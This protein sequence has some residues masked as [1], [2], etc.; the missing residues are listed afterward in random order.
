MRATGD[1]ATRKGKGSALGSL[2]TIALL[3]GA[4]LL[5]VGGYYFFYAQR[6]LDYLTS[7]NFRL[8]AT[9]G[10]QVEESI[11]AQSTVL[12]NLASL[13]D[14]DL[15]EAYQRI[16][17]MLHDVGP[18]CPTAAGVAE[19]AGGTRQQLEAHRGGYR[20]RLSYRDDRAAAPVQLCGWATL[21]EL[22]EP[23]L[24]TRK[25]FDAVLL[26]DEHGEVIYQQGAPDLGV[27]RLDRLLDETQ[28]A[29]AQRE[30]ERGRVDFSSFMS[31]SRVVDVQASGRGFKVFL[32][33]VSLSLGS[34]TGA[35]SERE[36]HQVWLLGGLVSRNNFVLKSLAFS[37]SVL[38]LLL[39]VLV[40]VA[41]SW[42]LLK[43]KLLGERQRLRIADV[44]LLGVCSLLGVSVLLLLALDYFAYDALKETARGQ[45]ADF[46]HRMT[47]NIR[48]E[49]RLAA[50]QL[51]A[52]EGYADPWLLSAERQ[53]DLLSKAPDKLGRY[54]FLDVFT[55]VD[56]MGR[57]RHKS[58]VDTVTTPLIDVGERS[59]YT[60]ARA[61]WRS[62]KPAAGEGSADLPVIVESIVGWSNGARLAVVAKPVEEKALAGSYAVATLA[63]PMLSA[64]DPLLA[65]GF[66]FAVVDHQGRVAFHSDQ[67]RN[68]VEDLFVETDQ[69]RRLRA[70]VF[71][72]REEGFDVRYWGKDYLAHVTPVAELPWTVVALQDKTLLRSVNAEWNTTALLFLLLYACSLTTLLVAVA[73]LR[74]R[75]RAD[76]LWPDPA[77]REAYAQLMLGFVLLAAACAAAVYLLPGGGRLVAVSWLCPF[78][79]L[80]LA[81]FTL[82]RGPVDVKRLATAA[83]G[84]ILLA[85]LLYALRPDLTAA[86]GVFRAIGIV[87]TPLT[88]MAAVTWRA[89]RWQPGPLARLPLARAYSVLGLLLVVLAA[90]LPT[91]GFFKTAHEIHLRSFGRYGQLKLAVA[92]QDRLERA[93]E[94]YAEQRG[95]GKSALLDHPLTVS[96]VAQAPRRR[97]LRPWQRARGALDDYA[98]AF[99]GTRFESADGDARP[100]E[101]RR[102]EVL[103]ALLEDLLPRYSEYTAESRELLHDHA[104]DCRWDWHDRAGGGLEL[105][106]AGLPVRLVSE[107]RLAESPL[108][109]GLGLLFPRLLLGIGFGAAL[110]ALVRFT[111]RRLFLVDL[112]EP[113]WFG[114]ESDLPATV[115]C[116]LLLVSRKR[117]W[118]VKEKEKHFF[119]LSVVE[120]E[121]EVEGWPRRRL[122]LTGSLPD[123]NIL[124]E[125]FEHRIFDA[126]F[127]ERKLAFLEDL[128]EVHR[129]TVVVLSAVSPVCLVSADRCTAARDSGAV[130]VEQ[131]W[132]ALL[133][134]FTIIDQD[135]R[136]VPLPDLGRAATTGSWRF[137]GLIDR[138]RGKGGA[139]APVVAPPPVPLPS[140]PLLRAECRSDP[141]L[142]QIA[143]DLEPHAADMDREQLLEEFGE[144]AES[145][146]RSLWASCS[147]DEKVL[148]EHVAEDG[149]V[150]AKS[151]RLLRRL[152]V[153]GLVQRTPTFE[154]MNESFRRFVIT[155]A[156]KSEVQ[157]LERS[158]ERSAWDKL[159]LPF[160]SALAASATFFLTT[161]QDLLDGTIAV[162]TGVTGG[163]PVL[164]KLVEYIAGS[165]GGGASSPAA[166]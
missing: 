42:P 108:A 88:C 77:R 5:I 83:C 19:P 92:L 102:P 158:A 26:A 134:S 66:E 13:D 20:L 153:R 75:Y 91:L 144:R 72:R 138:M 115:G 51:Q 165:R 100:C 37:S 112:A 40:V 155:A 82:R 55:L 53:N 44:L 164:V 43:L 11:A 149:L 143:R 96:A 124:V 15:A 39:G 54:P 24:G 9:M 52:M 84:V 154:V 87:A 132:R 61:R 8:L 89:W 27:H 105:H 31:S 86:G 116:N 58:S 126:A 145:Y 136:S 117:S 36:P 70:A 104:S 68:L 157:A 16:A 6:R 121:D 106:F 81:Y 57:Q 114:H 34:P 93:R 46:A 14:R 147:Q 103:P 4:L 64:I 130:A 38:T 35:H 33:P 59:Y 148:L 32:Q 47:R 65:P 1:H 131:R 18:D 137:Q 133:S 150:N 76:W 2:R 48:G 50:A 122:E 97:E 22:L 162:L 142:L 95:Q 166:D 146:Y 107:M 74:P 30:G 163:L 28:A 98:G 69:N 56:P 29:R 90:V 12:K 71:A 60:R 10:E 49:V 17:P 41:V 80:A 99:Y 85:G 67:G 113:L 109:A 78:V 152:I 111:A 151:R 141:F 63:I 160:L 7:R 156:C 159:Q 161:Q 140:V 23:L 45:L 118:S 21:Q 73:I 119:C 120:L 79:A 3:V 127:N 101:A 125:G 25:A 135:L 110:L 128:V 129:R 123:R 94:V 139:E 62:S